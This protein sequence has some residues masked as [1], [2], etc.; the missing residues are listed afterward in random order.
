[1][2]KFLDEHRRK[3]EMTEFLDEHRR[4]MERENPQGW[5]NV[6]AVL[7]GIYIVGSVGAFIYLVGS[8]VYWMIF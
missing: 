7:A 1:M 3:W 2:T 4:E 6:G 8:M 5:T